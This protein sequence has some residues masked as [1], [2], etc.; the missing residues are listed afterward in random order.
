MQDRVVGMHLAR[1]LDSFRRDLVDPGKDERNGEAHHQQQEHGL[2]HPGGHLEQSEEHLEDL[3]REVAHDH[4]EHGHATDV[5]PLE[6]VDE[7]EVDRHLLAH[8]PVLRTGMRS[9]PRE[10]PNPTRRAKL[11]DTASP[12]G[13]SQYPRAALYIR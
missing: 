13:A 5:A 7:P 10:C 8:E 6:L 3:E 9:A 2:S 12:Y 1:Q 4:V 11:S